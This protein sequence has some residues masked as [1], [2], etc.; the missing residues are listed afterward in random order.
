MYKYQ[1][2][3]ENVSQEFTSKN[4][5]EIQSYF[6]KEIDQNE[7]MSKKHKKVSTILNSTNHFLILVSASTI[8]NYA[9]HFLILVSASTILNY[10]NHFLIL[11]SAT[12]GCVSI[13]AFA[14][15]IGIP[16]RIT[17]STVG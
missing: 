9:N 7:S 14:S 17:S 16:I 6:I 2:K 1:M 5:E 10:T 11:V 4:I 13:S 15:L 8:L 12:V 3:E